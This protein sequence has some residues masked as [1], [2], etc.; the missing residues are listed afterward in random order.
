[1]T[2]EQMTKY[3]VKSISMISEQGS[4]SSIIIK[5]NNGKINKIKGPLHIVFSDEYLLDIVKK[6]NTIYLRNKKINKLIRKNRLLNKI[7]DKVKFN[8]KNN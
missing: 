4:D 6:D 2:P 8:L 7:I 1:M 5:Y 3:G